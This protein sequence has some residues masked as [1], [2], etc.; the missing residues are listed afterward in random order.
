MADPAG[1]EELLTMDGID[2]RPEHRHGTADADYESAV[3]ERLRHAEY[4]RKRLGD[5]ILTQ[6]F[7]RLLD[8]T[9]EACEEVGIDPHGLLLTDNPPDAVRS[10][11]NAV[12]VTNVIARLR[13]HRHRDR[14]FPLEQHDRTDMCVLALAIPHCSVVATE[15]RWV[16]AARQAGLDHRYGA[17]LCGSLTE[18]DRALDRLALGGHISKDDFR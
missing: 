9:N 15:K 11:V 1:P 3:R 12:P 8:C 13:I 16:H 5:F 18:L 2:V 6:E 17:D 14:G 7:I 4:S 10:F